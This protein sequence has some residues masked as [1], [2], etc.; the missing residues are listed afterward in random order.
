MVPLAGPVQARPGG[1]KQRG[2][3]LIYPESSWLPVN[4]SPGLHA[5]HLGIKFPSLHHILSLKLT[6]VFQVL[7]ARLRVSCA[8]EAQGEV[9]AQTGGGCRW[10]ED[11]LPSL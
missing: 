3:A 4:D 9:P 7:G 10:K 5:G 6:V 1:R 2:C 11:R 8:G